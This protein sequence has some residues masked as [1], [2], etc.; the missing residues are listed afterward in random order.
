MPR[1]VG[2]KLGEDGKYHAPSVHT[3]DTS[4]KK[5][6]LF[7]NRRQPGQSLKFFGGNCPVKG[8]GPQEGDMK[9]YEIEHGE[10][11]E[12]TEE[13]AH[14]IK[15]KGRLKPI[16]EENERG[17]VRQTGRFYRDR[18]FDLYEV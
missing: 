12:L 17:E 6:Y 18:R 15:N 8:K 9:V 1:Q 16:T 7:E 14:H 10:E 4:S 13:M 11:V 5:K 3:G 2:D